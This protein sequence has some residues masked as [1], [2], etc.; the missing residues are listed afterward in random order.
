MTCLQSKAYFEKF[1][2][3]TSTGNNSGMYCFVWSMKIKGYEFTPTRRRWIL[4]WGKIALSELE[5]SVRSHSVISLIISSPFFSGQGSKDKSI[6]A[7]LSRSNNGVSEGSSGKRSCNWLE[8]HTMKSMKS[9]V[10]QK[11]IGTR[12]ITLV[13]LFTRLK[14][15]T[16]G[17]LEVV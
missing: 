11:G 15:S 2:W 3:I 12:E 1:V 9:W 17:T 6:P 13:F 4:S 7:V 16:Q 14:Q 8:I 10:S 5:V